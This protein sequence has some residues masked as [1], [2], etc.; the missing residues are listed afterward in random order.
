MH[1]LVN[2]LPI[3]KLIKIVNNM[4]HIDHVYIFC[5]SCC[6][7]NFE[8]FK[9]SVIYLHQ[10]CWHIFT[11]ETVYEQYNHTIAEIWSLQSE[12]IFTRVPIDYSCY[13]VWYHKIKTHLEAE[14]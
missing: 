4:M 13:S 10:I 7:V 8:Y 2:M 14:V 5:C 3:T 12:F 9:N 6:R 1:V 11:V